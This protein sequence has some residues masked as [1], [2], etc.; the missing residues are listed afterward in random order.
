LLLSQHFNPLTAWFFSACE[1]QK[2]PTIRLLSAV[3]TAGC[4][5]IGCFHDTRP[6][7]GNNIEIRFG[8]TFGQLSGRFVIG[9][10]RM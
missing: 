4:A 9:I 3:F 8:Q 2:L 6:A 1:K 10:S 5:P 7:T